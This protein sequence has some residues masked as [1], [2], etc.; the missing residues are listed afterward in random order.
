MRY[1]FMFSKLKLYK[2]RV[3]ASCYYKKIIGA[4]D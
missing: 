3:L 1:R 2:F 4:I